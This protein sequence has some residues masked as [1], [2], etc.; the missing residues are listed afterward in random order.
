MLVG[1]NLK[2]R[3]GRCPR[4]DDLGGTVPGLLGLG[5]GGGDPTLGVKGVW[6]LQPP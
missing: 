6:G 3:T 2:E 4:A 5:W 1:L